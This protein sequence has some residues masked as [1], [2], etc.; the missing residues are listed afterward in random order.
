[1][2]T[3]G[4]VKSWNDD[5][6]F[7]F[8]EPTHGGQEIFVHIKAFPH[9]AGRPRV[10]QY[11]SFEIE[12]NKEGKKRAKNVELLRAARSRG[13]RRFSATSE[14]GTVSLLAILAF[15]FLYAFVAVL[16]RVPNLVAGAYFVLSVA[17]FAAYAAD[18]SASNEGRRRTPEST[19]LLLGMLGG[20]PGGLLAQ[21]LLRH[22]S[23]K[24][25]FRGPFWCSVVINICV[26][27]ILSSPL[28]NAWSHLAK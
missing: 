14:W 15:L 18:K 20:W 26:F 2:R 17:C 13:P 4:L 21:Q 9:R 12:Q 1:M 8:I 10:G 16:W 27:V 23:L 25:S 19:L 28:V 3:E 24:G 22:K 6:G 7:G 5:R 11:V